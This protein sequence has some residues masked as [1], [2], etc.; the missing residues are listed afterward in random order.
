MELFAECQVINLSAITNC[1]HAPPKVS[2]HHLWGRRGEHE[3]RG[4]FFC[5]SGEKLSSLWSHWACDVWCPL[6]WLTVQYSTVLYSTVQYSTILYSEPYKWTPDVTRSVWSQ[7]GQLFTGN[8]KEKP[9]S[10]V[11][12]SPSSQMMTRHFWRSMRTIC[13]CTQINNLTFCKKL[14]LLTSFCFCIIM[15]AM[16][17]E[18]TRKTCHLWFLH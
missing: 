10:L 9:P 8:A 12:P 7:W 3:G 5:I 18:L 15:F 1:P 6:V 11:F 13:Y 2:C 14:H 17:F 16:A 4:F